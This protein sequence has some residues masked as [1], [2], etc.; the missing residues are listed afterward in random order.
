MW[1][2]IRDWYWSGYEQFNQGYLGV[3]QLA[4][5]MNAGVTWITTKNCNN[6][7]QTGGAVKWILAQLTLGIVLKIK[8][9]IWELYQQPY[10][11]P[12][13]NRRN[14][15]RLDIRGETQLYT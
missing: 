11:I 15:S 9:I 13:L 5:S 7:G 14:T 3:S 2:E 4:Q 6:N 12:S 8:L 1:S 10:I